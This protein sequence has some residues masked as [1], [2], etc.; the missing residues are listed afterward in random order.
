MTAAPNFAYRLMA[1]NLERPSELRLS[2]LR[3]AAN[4]GEPID[5]ETLDRLLEHG[6]GHGLRP[7]SLT[8][9]Y[10]LAEAA[11]AVTIASPRARFTAVTVDRDELAAGRVRV[12]SEDPHGLQVVSVGVPIG[13]TEVSILDDDGCEVDGAQTG[14]IA[15]RSASLMAG[16]LGEAEAQGLHGDWLL[17]GDVGF[18]WQGEL[19]VCGRRKDMIIIAG[20]NI[21]AENVEKAVLAAG[22]RGMRSPVAFGV[23]G[24]FGGEALVVLVDIRNRRR[25]DIYSRLLRAIVDET[26]V[27]ATVVPVP[28]G[29]LPK[30][31]SGKAQRSLCREKYLAGEF[32][33]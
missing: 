4:G 15:V 22:P 21:F 14:E 24:L 8:C 13:S 26:G 28:K 1:R 32:R 27:P 3:I 10:G 31:S 6:A 29:S 7:E 23:P 17:T 5:V 9:V 18:L 16:Y 33:E 12:L 30:T 20:A 25:S 2:D 19:F 11:L